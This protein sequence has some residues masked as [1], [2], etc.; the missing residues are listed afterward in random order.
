M[1][2]F[3]PKKL[4]SGDTLR[5]ISPARSG[6]I[7]SKEVIEIATKNLNKLG[8][9]VTFGKNWLNEKNFSS[10]S[11][12]DRVEDLHEAFN[13][14][15][16]NG[17]LTTTGGFNSNELLRYIDFDIIKNNPKVFCGFS[18]IT[19]LNN[20]ILAKTGLIT[21]S[22]MHFSTFGQKLMADYNIR[23]FQKAI[24][25]KEYI[26]IKPSNEWSDES[27]YLNQD[28]RNRIENKGYWLINEGKGEGTLLGGNL[29]TIR[30]LYGTEYMPKLDRPTIIFI[31]DA[32]YTEDDK[33]EFNRNLQ[34]LIHQRG[35][36]NVKGLVIG[37]FQ[38]GSKVSKEDIIKI[39]KTKKELD[40]IPVIANVDFG[41]TDPLITFPIGGNASLYIEGGEFKIS[42]K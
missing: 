16:I 22:G 6:S 37:R 36:E 34:S 27:W 14:K 12:K 26:D 11:I 3:Y 17:I 8:L 31:E 1:N 9:N 42:I 28:N 39:V 32:N 18:D 19:T 23:H 24:M 7:L 29:A 41:H 13:D 15:N 30:L 4:K 40:N 20:A 2:Y 33:T 38:I 10:A 25:T 21:Y 35:F 5:I